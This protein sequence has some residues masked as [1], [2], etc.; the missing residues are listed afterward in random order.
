MVILTDGL[1]AIGVIA[2]VSCV[3]CAIGL[4]L[5]VRRDDKRIKQAQAR[6]NLEQAV[7]PYPRPL[8][9]RSAVRASN[10][11]CHFP[12]RDGIEGWG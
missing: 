5:L 3:F 1:E 6:F 11:H 8:D 9:L 12:P 4:A 10:G 7:R 2:V